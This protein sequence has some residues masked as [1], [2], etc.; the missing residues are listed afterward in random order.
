MLEPWLSDTSPEA[1]RVYLELYRRMSP[2]E[3]LQRVFELCDFQQSLQ[4][5]NVRAMYPEAGEEEV[6]LRVGG[7]TPGPGPDDQSLRLGP[8]TPPL[9][10]LRRALESVLA[11]L[12]RLEIPYCVGGSVA[13]SAYGLPRQTNDIDILADFGSV[14]IGEFYEALKGEFYVDL[15]IASEAIKQSRPFNAIHLQGAFKFDFFP[16]SP[17]GF[18]KSELDRRRYLVSAIPGLEDVEFPIASPEDTVLAKLLWFRK[19]GE[20]S[21]RQWHDILGILTTQSERLDLAY[22]NVWAENLAVT[23]LL[24]RAL[25]DSQLRP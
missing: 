4:A 24:E 14:E 16:A 25:R 2:A 6:F 13:S 17:V 7:S 18:T 8:G 20:V 9:T 22:M 21:D 19:G 1:R 5:A 3:R 15:Q 23:D 12:D 11:V 10:G